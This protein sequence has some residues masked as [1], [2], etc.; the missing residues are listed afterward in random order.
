MLTVAET[1][2]F[3]KKLQDMINRLKGD[4]VQLENETNEHEQSGQ[5]SVAQPPH[6]DEQAASMEEV[7]T[8]TLLAN[9][10]H[11]MDE[12]NAAMG[13]IG[14]G[15]FGRCEGCGEGITKSRLRALPYARY[16]TA[17]AETHEARPVL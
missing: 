9:E 10:Q 16:C 6:A 13:R 1:R 3:Q 7:V 4:C 8:L 12:I 2:A 5:E 15:S 17:C 14:D 11:M